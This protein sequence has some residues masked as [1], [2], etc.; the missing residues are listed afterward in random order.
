MAITYTQP[1]NVVQIATKMGTMVSAMGADANAAIMAYNQKKTIEVKMANGDDVALVPY[2]AVQ[3]FMKAITTEE[4]TKEDAYCDGESGGDD[5]CVELFSGTVNVNDDDDGEMPYYIGMVNG[6]IPT[7]IPS[8]ITYTINGQTYENMP[9]ITTSDASRT[10]EYG[11]K[12]PDQG[13]IPFGIRMGINPYG[14]STASVIA[15][16]SGEYQVTILD[17]SSN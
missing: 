11:T 2:H 9:N 8:K 5:E 13:D 14:T 4:A 7:S 1:I 16:T 3:V 12:R 10:G 15:K 6:F 17:C